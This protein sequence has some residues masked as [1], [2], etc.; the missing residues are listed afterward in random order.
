M[1]TTKPTGRHRILALA[2][3]I[4]AQAFLSATVMAGLQLASVNGFDLREHLPSVEAGPDTI[5][6]TP[7]QP[8]RTAGL[9]P[10][11][12]LPVQAGGLLESLVPPEPVQ[13]AERDSAGPMIAGPFPRSATHGTAPDRSAPAAERLFVA[14]ARTPAR[15]VAVPTPRPVEIAALPRVPRL[16]AGQA[17]SVSASLR[18]TE[19]DL[20][21]DT[22]HRFPPSDRPDVSRGTI[23]IY[24]VA[25]LA[26]PD[27]IPVP[28][29]AEGPDPVGGIVPY[30]RALLHR[31]AD[32]TG[33]AAMAVTGTARRLID[34]V[35]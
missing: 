23:G 22:S 7:Q 31:T 32:I 17:S 34:L 5:A 6:P 24:D 14:P 15:T 18:D 30:G 16:A 33:T 1:T 11:Y 27:A 25:E 10:R 26:A 29:L 13:R 21:F 4:G 3:R 2:R 20:P 12:D 35:R 28:I 8:M 19:R 9:P